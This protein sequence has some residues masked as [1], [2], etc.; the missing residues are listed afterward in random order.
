MTED[1]KTLETNLT[2][3]KKIPVANDKLYKKVAISTGNSPKLVE[4]VIG[5]VGKFTSDIIK[6]GAFETVMI[7]GFGKFKPKVKKV[8]WATHR[9]VLPDLPMIKP[10]EQPVE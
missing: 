7:P 6:R 2:K 5:Y 10:N 3:I 1:K 9:H 4:D 8:Q